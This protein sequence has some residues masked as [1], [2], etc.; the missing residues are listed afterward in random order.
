MPRDRLDLLAIKTIESEIVRMVLLVGCYTFFRPYMWYVG[1]G[2]VVYTLVLGLGNYRYKT[3]HARVHISRKYFDMGKIKELVSLG[4]WNSV[5]RLGQTLLEGLDLLIANILIDPGAMGILDFA[6]KYPVHRE[7]DVQCVVGIFNPQITILYA[8]EKYDEMVQMIKS[9]N[10]I[11][12]FM[13]SIP[14]AFVTAFGD[15]FL[16]PVAAG[17]RR[18]PAASALRAVHGHAVCQHEYPG[19]LPHFHHHEKG[20]GELLVVLLSGFLVHGHGVCC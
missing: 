11:T 12:I 17:L 15:I 2:S 18:A 10:R 13:L 8:E 3:A 6:K 20:K 4:A 9:A 19:A 16:L 1:I 14:I 7:P 5:T